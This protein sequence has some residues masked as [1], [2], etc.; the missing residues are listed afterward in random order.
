VDQ[1]DV[2]GRPALIYFSSGAA[3]TTP[4]L[5]HPSEIRWSRILKGF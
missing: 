5:L 3:K 1:N 4:L 2:V